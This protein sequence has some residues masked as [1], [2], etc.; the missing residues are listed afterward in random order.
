MWGY[1]EGMGWWMVLGGFWVVVVWGMVI[2]LG[3]WVFNRSAGNRP[4]ASSQADSAIDIAKKR[5]ASGEIT[6]EEFE[7]LKDLLV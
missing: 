3:A 2:G 7:T 5:F 6:R 1:H 4:S